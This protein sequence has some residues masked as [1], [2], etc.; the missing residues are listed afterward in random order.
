M[1]PSRVVPK[2]NHTSIQETQ[3]CKSP[4][5]PAYSLCFAINAAGEWA[6]MFDRTTGCFKFR[7]VNQN[8]GDGGCK[9]AKI[10]EEPHHQ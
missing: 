3:N 2:I 10:A 8:L 4:V 7:F 9:M 5:E 1:L 6:D